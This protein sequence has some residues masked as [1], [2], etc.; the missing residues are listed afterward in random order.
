MVKTIA[1]VLILTSSTLIGFLLANRYGQRVKELRLIYSALKHFETEIIYG[2]TPM[3]EA[4]RNIA[5]RMESPISNVYY[6]MSEKF[7]EHE[8]STV[9]IWQTCWRDNRRHLALTKRDYDILMQLGYSIGQ[10]DK[11]NQLKHIGIA[12]SYIQAEEEEAR[13]DQQKHEKMYKYLGFLMGLMVVILM[14]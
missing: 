12:L 4:L 2:L 14:M 5:K 6:E 9:D 7:S 3:P 11:E 8:L 13:H 10:T 1:I